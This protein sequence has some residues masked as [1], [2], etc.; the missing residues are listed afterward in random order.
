MKK[1]YEGAGFVSALLL[2]F[3]TA[4]TFIFNIKNHTD[5][6][7]L[8]RKAQERLEKKEKV[9]KKNISDQYLLYEKELNSI[10][11]ELEGYY[12]LHDPLWHYYDSK[13]DAFKVKPG[14]YGKDNPPPNPG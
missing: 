11:K 6:S 12:K 7:K 8:E 5:K 3:T 4:S 9:S 13:S 1:I 14:K 2:L 10:Q